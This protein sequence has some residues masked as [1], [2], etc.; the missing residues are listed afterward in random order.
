M[1]NGVIEF[2]EFA[3]DCDRYAL[4]RAG[5]PIKLEKLP[6]ELLILLLEKD[7][8][9][10]TRQEI[11]ERLWG[12]DVFLDTE[13]GINTAVR[14]LR[15]A[16]G[17]NPEQSR[18]V[19]TVTGK[20]YRFIAAVNASSS[21][22][23]NGNNGHA[24]FAATPSGQ[25]EGK[26]PDQQGDHAG[27]P[28]ETTEPARRSRRAI[29]IAALLSAIA[30][31]TAAT[32]FIFIR[33]VGGI[34][35][36]IIGRTLPSRIHSL[37][38]LPLENVSG[39]PAQDYFADGMTD[40]LTTMLAKN[41]GS[42]V[43]S[44]TSAMQ[45]K[46]THLPL[47]N[48]AREL[49]VDGILEGSVARS[50]GRVHLNVQLVHAPSDTHV[51]AESYDRDSSDVSALQNELARTIARQVGL[52][53]SVSTTPQRRISP[54]AHDAYLWGRYYWFAD[55]PEKSAEYFQKSIDLQPDYA[56]A[57]SGLADSLIVM[58]VN[59]E[60]LP[61]QVMARGEAAAR[62]A[63]ELDD[64]VAET[65]RTMAAVYLFFR[66]D[67]AQADRE[68]TRAVELDPNNS[69]NHHLRAYV[70]E[71]LD[72]KSE[73]LQEQKKATDLD[74]LTRP[75]AMGLL[76]IRLHQFDAAI[77][78]ARLREQARPDQAWLHRVLAIAYS[79]KGMEKESAEEWERLLTIEGEQADADTVRRT[80][81]QGGLKAVQQWWL[82]RMHKW[83]KKHYYS[84][85]F[86]ALDYAPL[87]RKEDTLRCL[88]EA[89]QQRAPWMVF[90]QHEPDLDFLHSE[91][92]YQAIVRKIGLPV[93]Q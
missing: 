66:W 22:Q 10:V 4:L 44:R 12:S 30:I 78:E 7:G 13:H 38:V 59:G 58:A 2:E 68:S 16:L 28:R 54:E 73:A 35:N 3:V 52:T 81:A 67:F 14:K 33:D 64:Q 91:P 45:Y 40:E 70:L 72:R 65:H 63:I 83:A 39:D 11:I 86:Q 62:K 56:E 23:G 21:V 82:E 84:P 87:K 43:V 47:P 46:R 15:N 6:M 75:F 29:R 89:Y 17:D 69:E 53:V 37:A 19:Q 71:V 20:G 34:R 61:R 18:F 79:S 57:W 90:M 25:A 50:G 27:P 88:D 55:N 42:R 8:H 48:I 36:R 92:R 41:S 9:L 60:T 93:S 74:P 32:L 49:G 5:Q 31:A 76:L 51:W 80:F 85:Y 24:G 1:P 77:N 26:H